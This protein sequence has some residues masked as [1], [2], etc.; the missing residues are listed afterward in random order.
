M[1][2]TATTS[3]ITGSVPI[4]IV[5]ARLQP[6]LLLHG[7]VDRDGADRR[8]GSTVVRNV[9]G[10]HVFDV[11]PERSADRPCLVTPA[12]PALTSRTTSSACGDA[13]CWRGWR[14]GCGR[15]PDD[16]NLILPFDEVVAAL[17]I[18]GERRLG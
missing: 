16:V 5:V 14:T 11:A 2:G 1:S 17:G 4:G 8:L 10:R 3:P 13:R 6:P 18:E 15:E 9:V 7:H 12:S